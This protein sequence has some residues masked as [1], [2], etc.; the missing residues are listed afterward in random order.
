MKII[1]FISLLLLIKNVNSQ[2]ND[3]VLVYGNH[4]SICYLPKIKTLD[5]IAEIK[6]FELHT[7]YIFSTINSLKESDIKLIKKH[8]ENG[9]NIYIGLDNWPQQKEGIE[10]LDSLFQI[11]FFDEGKKGVLKKGNGELNG[12]DT[13][14]SFVQ[15]NGYFS[16]KA[17]FKIEY[18]SNDCPVIM[19]TTIDK[20][21][22]IIDAGYV[23]FFCEN[24]SEEDAVLLKEIIR[25]LS[26]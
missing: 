15:T 1:L 22:L 24:I 19:S 5:S 3:T 10:I 17:N 7:L 16:I 26:L 18:W 11:H 2:V 9:G 12:P 14:N 23:R 20:G 13:I 6:N 8:L 25:Y 4:H 21:K